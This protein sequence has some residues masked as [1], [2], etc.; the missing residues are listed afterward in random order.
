MS[1]E[2]SDGQRGVTRLSFIKAGAGVLAGAAGVAVPA[3]VANAAEPR[4]VEVRPSGGTHREPV[5]AYVRDAKRGEVTVV[6]GM[7]EKTYRDPALVRRLLAAAPK[8]G[9]GS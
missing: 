8:K 6:A 4:A 5:V 7:S 2:N 1:E 3:A 9:G